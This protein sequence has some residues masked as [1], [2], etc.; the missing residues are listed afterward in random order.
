M[1]SLDTPV[2]VQRSMAPLGTAGTVVELRVV[3]YSCT[4]GMALP[5]TPGMVQSAGRP[6]S[7]EV[8]VHRWYGTAR[9]YSGTDGTVLR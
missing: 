6:E 9:W 3:W 4:A 7:L 2:M 5:D 1:A 8:Q